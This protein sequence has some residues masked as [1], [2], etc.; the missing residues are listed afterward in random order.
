MTDEPNPPAPISS[1]PVRTLHLPHES[2]RRLAMLPRTKH[3]KEGTAAAFAGTIAALPSATNAVIHAI[4]RNTFGEIFEIIQVL[5]CF[6]FLVWLIASLVYSREEKTSSEYLD[7]LY[8][9][10]G[11]AVNRTAAPTS[12]T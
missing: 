5:I 9:P 3:H 11:N 2:A 7:E 8:G 10:S 4:R 12:G 1:E 6:G